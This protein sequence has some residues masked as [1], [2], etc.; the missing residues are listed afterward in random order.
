MSRAA[1]ALNFG[2]EETDGVERM[3]GVD[4]AVNRGVDG[5]VNRGVDGDDRAAG[6]LN[7][8]VEGV[9]GDERTDAEGPELPRENAPLAPPEDD[10]RMPP[11]PP[12]PCRP[13][14][15]LWP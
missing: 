3:A 12:P 1:G 13:R 8:G 10:D 5:A 14:P 9:D 6:A 7:R 11:P 15:D 2:A 4:G